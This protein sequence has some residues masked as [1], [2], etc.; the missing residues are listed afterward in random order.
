MKANLQK[1]FTLIELMIVV[2]IIGIL[3]AVALPAYQDYTVR[4]RVSEGLVLASGLKTVVADNAS[5]GTLDADGGLFKGIPTDAGATTFCA[6]AGTCSLN[7]GVNS[8]NVSTVIGTTVNGMI[9]VTYQAAASGQILEMWPSS[10]GA[11]LAAGT[12]PASTLVWT[13]FAK[14]KA[15][16][17]G[18][19]NG[20][21]LLAK[22]APAECR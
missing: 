22:Y 18:A 5:N 4:S 14:G 19:T 9:Q 1:G 12:I 8:K 16:V 3:A 15:T 13:C 11:K 7:A 20:A 2:A 6:A 10:N 21:T 17:N